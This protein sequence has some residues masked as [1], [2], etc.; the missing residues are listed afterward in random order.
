MCIRGSGESCCQSPRYWNSRFPHF[1]PFRV[2][3]SAEDSGKRKNGTV[4]VG[5]CECKHRAAARFAIQCGGCFYLAFRATTPTLPHAWDQRYL[6]LMA[7]GFLVPFVW[8]FSAKWMS[9]FLG[10][11]TIATVGA[12]RAVLVNL[13]GVHACGCGRDLPASGLFLLGAT[14]AIAALRIFE[15]S[16]KEAKTRVSIRAFPFFVRMAYGWLLVAGA[17]GLAQSGGTT[18]GESGAHRVHALTVD[19]YP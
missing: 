2:S 3:T 11:E 16:V 19:L 13:L 7:W 8:G 6:A 15:P 5:R 18:P 10:F 1:R 12:I 14:L 17:L 4:G 9:V